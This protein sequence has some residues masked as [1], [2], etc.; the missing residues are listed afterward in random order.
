MLL[1]SLTLFTREENK[2]VPSA[3]RIATQLCRSAAL[4]SQVSAVEGS[5]AGSGRPPPPNAL[6]DPPQPTRGIR[7]ALPRRRAEARLRARLRGAVGGGLTGS[8]SASRGARGARSAPR[9]WRSALGTAR[10]RCARPLRSAPR[11]PR[12]DCEEKKRGF[13]RE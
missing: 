7:G 9:S 12:A 4:C 13:T 5:E 3:K 10:A 6:N 11:T 8:H 2:G 1:W